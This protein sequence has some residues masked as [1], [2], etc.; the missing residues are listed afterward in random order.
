MLSQQ[1][2]DAGSDYQ[3]IQRLSMELEQTTSGLELAFERWA[4]LAEIAEGLK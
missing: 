2:H 1:I 4:V 3:A